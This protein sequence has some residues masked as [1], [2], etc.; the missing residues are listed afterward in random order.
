VDGR[1][2]LFNALEDCPQ[3]QEQDKCLYIKMHASKVLS[4][5]LSV[6]VEDMIETEYGLV[7]SGIFFGKCMSKCM[8]QA[9]TRDHD[10]HMY[11]RISH[12]HLCTLIKIKKSNQ[13][14]TKKK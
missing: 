9:T 12:H 8:T 2:R 14:F 4:S 3:T 11:Q 6:E 10:Q 13:V 1:C 5:A 7:E